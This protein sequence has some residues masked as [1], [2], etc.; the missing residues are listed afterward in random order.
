MRFESLSETKRLS[1]AYWPRYKKY[2]VI[3]KMT[4]LQMPTSNTSWLLQ[5][6]QAFESEKDIKSSNT[7]S[8]FRRQFQSNFHMSIDTTTTTI[9]IWKKK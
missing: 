2:G 7:Y 8:V 3:W 5:K 6:R 9:S 4:E 1:R